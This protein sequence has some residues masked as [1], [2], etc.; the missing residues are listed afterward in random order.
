MKAVFTLVGLLIMVAA[1][2]FL[3]KKQM[4]SIMPTG[5]PPEISTQGG[6]PASL[7][8]SKPQQLPEQFK[9]AV[10]DAMQKPRSEDDSK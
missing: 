2:G 7:T 4:A 8:N 9:K 6:A 3:S 10:D 5:L 1:I